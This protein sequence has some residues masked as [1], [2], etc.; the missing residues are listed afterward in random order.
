MRLVGSLAFASLVVY[1][2]IASANGWLVDGKRL[3]PWEWALTVGLFLLAC[4]GAKRALK[5]YAEEAR[6]EWERGK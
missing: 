1:L 2:W 6:R 3:T 4:K 5:E